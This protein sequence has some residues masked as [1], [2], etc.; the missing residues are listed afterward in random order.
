M[1]RLLLITSGICILTM[2]VFAE[3]VIDQNYRLNLTDVDGNTLSNADARFNVVVLSSKTNSD[4]ARA[5]G[6]RIPDF[7]LGNADYRM[8][9]VVS[10]E[11]KHNGAVRAVLLAAIRHRLDSEAQ[12][13]QKRYE[14]H[15]IARDA[16]HDVFAVAD[17]DGAIA[18]QL[19]LQP[20]PAL[21]RVFVF[22]KNGELLRQW[23]D[24]PS[25]EELAAALSQN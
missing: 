25:E 17:F 23:N 7:C 12:R 13:L 10:F 6:D 4:K 19:D 24:V 9:T 2:S 3:P 20:E 1:K 14:E 22:G 15:K 18:A 8:I 21:F 11:T 5:V 16:R